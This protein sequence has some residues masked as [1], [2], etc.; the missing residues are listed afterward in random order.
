M[1]DLTTQTLGEL[2]QQAY[3][4]AVS[5]YFSEMKGFTD[6]AMFMYNDGPT[7]IKGSKSIDQQMQA[8]RY[9][10]SQL[11]WMMEDHVI[12]DLNYTGEFT[13]SYDWCNLAHQDLEDYGYSNFI[14]LV[15]DIKELERKG[16]VTDVT[17]YHSSEDSLII[18]LRLKDFECR[19]L[20]VFKQDYRDLAVIAKRFHNW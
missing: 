17:I 6:A 16:I 3:D 9:L 4:S 10:N 8:V 1:E 12:E 14:D 11:Q 18:D 7:S 15:I 2:V 5:T 19:E 13:P 20:E